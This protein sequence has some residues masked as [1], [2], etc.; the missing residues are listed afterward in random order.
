MIG[1]QFIDYCRV[2]LDWVLEMRTDGDR[3]LR[4]VTVQSHAEEA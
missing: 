4:G 2:V 3:G 1:A